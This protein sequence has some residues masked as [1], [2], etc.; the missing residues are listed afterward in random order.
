MSQDVGRNSQEHT[1]GMKP[2]TRKCSHCG[3]DVS[4][5]QSAC[6]VDGTPM[7]SAYAPGATLDG[8]Y[9]FLQLIG[10]G[11]MGVVYKARQIILNKVVAIK[12]LHSDVVNERAT[13]RFQREGKAASVLNH[14]NIIKIYDFAV[15]QHGQP[16]MVMDFVQGQTLE[17]KISADGC[18][19]IDFTID[20]ML[21]ICDALSHAHKHGVLHRDMKPSNVLMIVNEGRPPSMLI[22]DFGIA[23]ITDNEK[24]TVNLTQT[25]D[26]LGSPLYMSPEQCAGKEM[27]RRTELYHL[28]CT[29]YEC[30]TGLPPFVGNTIAQII[31][32]ITSEPPPSLK[33]SSLG[34]D[35]PPALEEIV[36]KLLN[37]NPDER[38]QSVDELKWVLEMYKEGEPVT[39]A[40]VR[41]DLSELPPEKSR[42]AK[43]IAIASALACFIALGLVWF[44][45]QHLTKT[46]PQTVAPVLPT[47]V[48]SPAG[49][50]D[51]AQTISMNVAKNVRE[52]VDKNPMSSTI[53]MGY[54]DIKDSD[55]APLA[56][57]TACFE[58][59]LPGNSIHGEGLKF[60]EPLTKLTSLR[61]DRNDVVDAGLEHLKNKTSLNRL[62]LN[63]TKVGGSGL[64]YLKDCP[65]V[66]LDMSH[67]KLDQKGLASLKSLS[68]VASIKFD[69]TSFNDTCAGYLTGMHN[70]RILDLSHTPVTDAG[71]AEISKLDGVHEL[72]LVGCDIDDRCMTSLGHMKGLVHLDISGTKVT[73]DGMR[74]LA[75]SKSLAIVYCAA[76]QGNIMGAYAEIRK[77]LPG[78]SLVPTTHRNN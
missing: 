18:L 52:W 23:K 24:A 54:W 69:D 53:D 77:H 30:L 47:R 19:E 37:K 72:W 26:T 59:N 29:M 56:E 51:G 13:K 63:T 4:A 12:M 7:E 50:A 10:A 36:M 11:G 41:I 65:L 68:N 58:L 67:N 27:D 9:E 60:I 62:N 32:K 48:T 44:T 33:D 5:T 14:P 38:Y 57:E 71:V 39:P 40:P 78:C 46:V 75:S 3:L 15:S 42:A 31:G 17:D 2:S 43:T 66:F 73:G 76:C 8:K 35:F 64:I 70:L 21:Q 22:L 34:K 1:M 74:A 49:T 25:G 45:I 16:Y 55:M 6:P 61:L 20:A 28:G